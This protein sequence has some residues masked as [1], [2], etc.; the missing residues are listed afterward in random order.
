MNKS[1]E[2]FRVD[3]VGQS[4]VL[5]KTIYEEIDIQRQGTGRLIQ[6]G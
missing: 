4:K 3:E 1:I 6:E 5:R 2:D